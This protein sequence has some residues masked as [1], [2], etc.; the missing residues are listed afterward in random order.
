V[1]V[2]LC[3]NSPFEVLTDPVS[4]GTLYTR[5]YRLTEDSKE[6]VLSVARS[7]GSCGTCVNGYDSSMLNKGFRAV[8]IATVLDLNLDDDD[9]PPLITIDAM[10]PSNDLGDDPCQTEYDIVE[11]VPAASPVT[12]EPTKRPTP[13]PTPPPTKE[14]S[15]SPV[16]DTP[17]AVPT[18]PPTM[19]PVTNAPDM[20]NAPP[21]TSEPSASPVTDTPTAVPTSPPTMKPVTNAPDLGNALGESSDGETL[22]LKQFHAIACFIISAVLL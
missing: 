20:G 11:G 10:K 7:V 9:A 19:K 17:T 21:P 6:E 14:S 1:D 4:S 3:Y 2:S 18:S 5:G 16:T 15:A 12:D 22:S 13:F 8:M